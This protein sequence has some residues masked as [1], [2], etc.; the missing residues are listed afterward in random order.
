ML[1]LLLLLLLLVLLLLLLLVVRWWCCWWCNWQHQ[2]VVRH[3][4][5]LVRCLP[6][7][8]VPKGAKGCQGALATVGP[9]TGKIS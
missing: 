9:A 7:S 4:V 1:P 8:T 3:V 6:I 5:L 2:H